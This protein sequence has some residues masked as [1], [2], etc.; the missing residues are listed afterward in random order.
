MDA[1]EE[2][3]RFKDFL[4]EYY[5]KIIAENFRT[6]RNYIVLDF[7][8]LLKF[9]TDL[10]DS[11]LDNPEDSI[12]NAEMAIQQYEMPKSVTRFNVRFQNI[13]DTQKL[14]LGSIRTDKLKKFH[15]FEGVVRQK[16]DVLPQ[17]ISAKFE[18][19]SCGNLITILQTE[20]NYKEPT[21]CGCGRK[22]KF[23]L[24]NKDLIDA[25]SLMLEECSESLEG[26]AQAK[27]RRVI[28]KEDLVSPLADR[29]TNPGTKIQIIGFVKEMPIPTRNGA[30]STTSDLMIEANHVKS[31]EDSYAEIQITDADLKE[32]TR[33]SKDK[34]VYRKLVDSIIPGRKGGQKIKEGLILQLFG[35]VKMNQEDGTILRGDIHVLLIGDPGVAKS[36]I[37]ERIENVAPKARFVSGEGTS[38]AGI[39]ASV[40]RDDFSGGW[41]LEAGALVLANKGFIMIDEMDKMDAEDR[42]HM[43]TALEKQ[44]VNINK[45]NIQATLQAETSVLAA[46]NPKHGRFDPFELVGKQINMPSTLI[47]RF[48]LIF[49][50]IDTPDEKKDTAIADFILKSHQVKKQTKEKKTPIS[51]E[52]LRKF[53]SYARQNVFPRLSREATKEIRD[54]YVKMRNQNKPE[55]K[56]IRA[57]AIS[58]R[59]LEGMVR[60][61]KASAKTRLSN[62]ATLE[63]AKRA[64]KLTAY[65][66]EKV[67]MDPETG[68]IDIDRI[69]SG[70]STSERSNISKITEIIRKLEDKFGTIIKIDDIVQEAKKEDIGADKVDEILK[71]LSRTG[72]IAYVKGHQI[73][74]IP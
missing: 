21:T 36:K 9:D 74:R 43:H 64:I 63:D 26:G 20:K 47:N 51:T 35:G 41:A 44:I 34:N 14:P 30:K 66:L 32:I 23:L 28:L 52:L 49:P 69:S 7:L 1:S 25:Q 40:I 53:I 48:D 37:L 17:T 57:I 38:G 2:I 67:G 55:G 45:A 54:Y 42:N 70:I 73:Q 68:K 62:V 50:L 60:L 58:A 16:S 46:A 24:I 27:R 29:K 3:N 11:L 22:G 19:P 31:I 8:E 71:K 6:G 65:C 5:S 4:D 56:G 12:K 59:Q 13:P 10:A 18:C 33:L 61:A 39:T 72:D 15:I